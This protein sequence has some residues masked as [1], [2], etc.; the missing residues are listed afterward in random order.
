MS[1]ADVMMEEDLPQL[2][3]SKR[4][5]PD[6]S[7]K[8]IGYAYGLPWVAMALYMDDIIFD[9]PEEAMEYWERI[10]GNKKA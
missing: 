10:Y 2:Y 3:V 4:K 1:K 6:G 8:V 9:T 5:M 7:E